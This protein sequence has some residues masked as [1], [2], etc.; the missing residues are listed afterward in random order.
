VNNCEHTE[1]TSVN[2]D[3]Q[4]TWSCIRQRVVL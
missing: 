2:N 3:L 4:N 1:M